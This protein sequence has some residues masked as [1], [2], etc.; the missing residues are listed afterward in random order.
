MEQFVVDPKAIGERVK[1]LRIKQKKTQSYYADMLYISP[2]YL[3]LIEEGARVPKIEVLVQ[4]ARVGGVSLDYLIFGEEETNET[5]MIFDRM[6]NNYT[7]SEI[8][9]A[10]L[11]AEYFLQLVHGTDLQ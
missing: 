5:K 6:Q 9:K 7:E 10:L 3:S 8:K 1:N 11:L 2:S 4:L